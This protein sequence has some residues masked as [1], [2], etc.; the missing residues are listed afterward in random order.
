MCPSFFP[1]FIAESLDIPILTIDDTYVGK[2][3]KSSADKFSRTWDLYY[4]RTREESLP[5]AVHSPPTW[6]QTCLAVIKSG[7]ERWQKAC[8]QARVPI[9]EF[10]YNLY[11]LHHAN[12]SFTSTMLRSHLDTLSAMFTYYANLFPE[13]RQLSPGDKRQLLEHNTKLFIQYFF[14]RY[15]YGGSGFKQTQWLLL[16][17][18]NCR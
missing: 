3:D 2:K 8:R 13:F 10:S 5:G 17:Q 16:C 7:R 18:V 12:Q 11:K 6:E 14:G 9:S 4:N 1:E 15:F